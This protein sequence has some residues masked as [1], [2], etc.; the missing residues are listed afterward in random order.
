MQ[1]AV[2]NVLIVVKSGDMNAMS[3]AE[4]MAASVSA[5]GARGRVVENRTDQE[6]CVDASCLVGSGPV[7]GLAVVLGG[8]GTMISVARKLAGSDVP[9]LGIN[10]GR[11]G[12]L[13]QITGDSWSD[14]LEQA[15]CKGFAVSQLIML[16][17][18]VARDGRQIFQSGAMND[19]VV[20]GSMARLIKVGVVFGGERLGG[21]RADGMV[22]A[23]PTGATAY[24]MSAGGP[25]V[26]PDLQVLTLTPICPFLCDFR[27]MVLPTDR[28]L[29]LGVEEATA[30]V[31]LTC[32][33]Q[34]TFSL[35]PGDW[36]RVRRAPHPLKLVAVGRH[37]YFNKLLDKG[38]IRER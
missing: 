4:T 8:D 30:E 34:S 6:G 15:V 12:F 22:V 7:P 24:S 21:F 2:R 19:V 18:E 28:P 31:V 3:L 35:R 17:C 23:T 20:R 16:S 25:L 33:G 37:S 5:M 36:V 9:L 14:H 26:H 10:L 38:F 29:D 27:P 13:T 1:P 11:L 32:D